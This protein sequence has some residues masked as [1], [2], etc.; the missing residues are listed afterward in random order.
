[1]LHLFHI[2]NKPQSCLLPMGE[3]EDPLT[4][5]SK[6]HI[7]FFN[8][9]PTL[10]NLSA[11]FFY[12]PGILAPPSGDVLICH[13]IGAKCLEDDFSKYEEYKLNGAQTG[14]VFCCR[15]MEVT[16]NK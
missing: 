14:L 6:V 2:L 3:R 16:V 9:S 8:S 7:G 5:N 11:G 1:M 15:A 13:G 4:L 12:F 10:F